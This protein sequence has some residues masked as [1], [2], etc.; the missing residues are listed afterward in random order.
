MTVDE[1]ICELST[2]KHKYEKQHEELKTEELALVTQGSSEERHVQH[3]MRRL[4]DM[5]ITLERAI[6]IV[7]QI[8]SPAVNEEN[9]S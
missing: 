6:A 7:C 3:T 8:K 2:M 9:D 4:A 1:A 5:I